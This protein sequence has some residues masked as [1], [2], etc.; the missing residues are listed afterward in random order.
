MATFSGETAAL[1]HST[2]AGPLFAASMGAAASGHHRRRRQFRRERRP[3]PPH[4]SRDET[5]L[6]AWRRTPSARAAGTNGLPMPK[7]LSHLVRGGA[8]HERWGKLTDGLSTPSCPPP[9]VHSGQ[10]PSGNR[11]GT[12]GVQ[13]PIAYRQRQS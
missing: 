10:A 7:E 11:S 3:N 13:S 9:A 8:L 5:I 2:M 1:S 12:F 6:M 4:G